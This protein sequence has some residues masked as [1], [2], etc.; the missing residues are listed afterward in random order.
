MTLK[1]VWAKYRM[2]EK[3]LDKNSLSYG[4]SIYQSR[5]TLSDFAALV[6]EFKQSRNPFYLDLRDKGT[7]KQIEIPTLRLRAGNGSLNLDLNGFIKKY[8]TSYEWRTNIANLNL[9]ADGSE[10][11]R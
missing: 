2:G 4:A 7:D 1:D 9:R 3:G 11:Y 10:V 5:I 6:P 8:G